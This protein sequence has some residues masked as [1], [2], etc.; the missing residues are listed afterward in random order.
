MIAAQPALQIP[1]RLSARHTATPQPQR[2]ARRGANSCFD[3][4][5]YFGGGGG[6]KISRLRPGST[7]GFGFGAFFTSFLPL[8][9]LPMRPS[10]SQMHACEKSL[11]L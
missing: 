9:L 8:S 3:S 4:V 1:A 2:L 6:E 7:F 11:V 10:I 5:A